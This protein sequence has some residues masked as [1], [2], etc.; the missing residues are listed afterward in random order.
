MNRC[1]LAEAAERPNFTQLCASIAQIL[2][3]ASSAYGY[4]LTLDTTAK[5]QT[6]EAR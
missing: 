4:L 1:F 2:N 3:N 6:D 5:P